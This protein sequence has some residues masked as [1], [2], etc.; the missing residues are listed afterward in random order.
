[1]KWMLVVTAVAML[2]A[3][4]IGCQNSRWNQRTPCTSAQPEPCYSSSPSMQQPVGT[5]LP[6]PG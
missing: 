4:S 3:A 6:A 1:M 5:Y 2:T